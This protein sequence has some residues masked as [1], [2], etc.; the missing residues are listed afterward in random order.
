MAQPALLKQPAIEVVEQ[1]DLVPQEKTAYVSF[2]TMGQDPKTGE[3]LLI[4]RRACFDPD[5]DRPGMKAHGLE[6][7]LYWMCLNP[8]TMV[9]TEPEV[10]VDGKDYPPGLIDGTLT[11][12]DGGL[13]LFFRRYP[14]DEPLY[15]TKGLSLQEL[16][17]PRLFP[18][19]PQV[20]V[21][22]QWGQ[23]VELP[24]RWL[25]VGYG[26]NGQ[27]DKLRELLDLELP[28]M[29]PGIYESLD[30]GLTWTFVN[31]MTPEIFLD[32]ELSANETAIL[33]ENGRVWAMMR[34]GWAWPG[35]MY[36]NFSDDGG[37]TWS[38]PQPSGL[39]G[40]AP[41]WY[42][43]PTGEIWLGYRGFLKDNPKTGGTFELAQFDPEQGRLSEPVVVEAYDGNH[44][45]GGYGTLMWLETQQKLL[46][47]YYTSDTPACRNPWLRYSLIKV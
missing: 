3:V 41:V 19:A 44:Y 34:T 31:W 38:K 24:D 18:L 16:M 32:E 12:I 5:D 28:I 17:E 46:A 13:Y 20:E 8:E 15:Y 21:G 10:L 36:I 22:A 27:L 6:G 29:L 4:F 14:S 39:Y 1:G 37:R 2:P 25:Q 26:R 45:D 47:V 9:W 35:P 42:R 40:E 23:V 33:Y 11:N 43:M 7:S 30:K